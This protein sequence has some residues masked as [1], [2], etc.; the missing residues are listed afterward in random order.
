MSVL[1]VL[2]VPCSGE[3]DLL[4]SQQLLQLGKAMSL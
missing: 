3:T 1:A 2:I 4:F